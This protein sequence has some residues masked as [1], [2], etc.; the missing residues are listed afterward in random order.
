MTRTIATALLLTAVA[1]CA[2]GG[3]PAQGGPRQGAPADSTPAAP[4]NTTARAELRDVN[5]NAIGS[6]SLTQTTR[7]VLVVGHLTSL[8]PG[9]HAIH[10][11]DVGRCEPP[12]TSAGGHFNP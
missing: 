10:V 11:H 9:P 8:P 5:G 2:S 1:A 3:G 7:G 12:F 6:V 4:P